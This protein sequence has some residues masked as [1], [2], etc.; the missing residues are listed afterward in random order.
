MP[1]SV[2][3][4]VVGYEIVKAQSISSKR[5]SHADFLFYLSGEHVYR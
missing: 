1:T 5:G 3:C 4:Y 2:D